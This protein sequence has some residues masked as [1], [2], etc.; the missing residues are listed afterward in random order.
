[1]TKNGRRALF[2][3]VATI[4]NMILTIIIIV[5]VGLGL[6]LVCTAFHWTGPNA[7]MPIW[8]VSFL[9]GVVL[10]AVVYSKVLKR[11]RNRPGLAE[12]FGLLK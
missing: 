11:L 12:R 3:L 4:A 1:M 10:S 2:L 9:S 7:A 5:A 6:S 8:I